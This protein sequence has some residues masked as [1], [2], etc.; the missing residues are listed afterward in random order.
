ME[1]KNPIVQMFNDHPFIFSIVVG[2][3]AALICN[4]LVRIIRGYPPVAPDN[5]ATKE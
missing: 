1:K 3:L 2:D 5:D 4:S